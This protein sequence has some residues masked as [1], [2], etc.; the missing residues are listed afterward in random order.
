[1][2]F[3]SVCLTLGQWSSGIAVETTLAFTGFEVTAE[4]SFGEVK[5]HQCILYL[6]HY[7]GLCEKF[8]NIVTA[9]CRAYEPVVSLAPTAVIHSYGILVYGLVSVAFYLC[10]IAA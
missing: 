4:I 5:A 3:R 7:T 9:V 10:G 1:M 6:K 2:L 8:L